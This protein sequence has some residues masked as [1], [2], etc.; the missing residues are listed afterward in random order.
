V[1]G[2]VETAT[3]AMDSSPPLGAV[4]MA[5]VGASSCSTLRGRPQT[6]Q[7]RYPVSL[8]SPHDGHFMALD[9]AVHLSTLPGLFDPLIAF[10]QMHDGVPA[11]SGLGPPQ[12]QSAI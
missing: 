8:T 12:V 10:F 9:L 7:N 2:E 1:E 3:V 5:T 4:G 11:I 6:L